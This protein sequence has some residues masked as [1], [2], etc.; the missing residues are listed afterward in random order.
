MLA[1]GKLS[2]TD[3][4]ALIKIIH[5]YLVSKGI[6]VPTGNITPE[7]KTEIKEIKKDTREEVKTLRKK[8]QEELKNKREEARAKI[9]AIR[10]STA[11]GSV[12]R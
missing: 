1:M 11:S 2:P 10:T 7:R 3:R 5:D 4:A 6:T 9:R 12:N 8:N